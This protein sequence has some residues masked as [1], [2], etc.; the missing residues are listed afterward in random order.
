M[1]NV[2]AYSQLTFFKVGNVYS[3]IMV[4]QKKLVVALIILSAVIAGYF[5]YINSSGDSKICI[6]N[7][8]CFVIEI[9]DSDYER[10]LGLG[11]RDFLDNESGM[12]F[13]FEKETIP[14]LWMKDMKFPIDI[15]WINSDF[16][17]TGIEKDLRPCV[18]G[19]ICPIV[20][21]SAPVKYVFEI[22]AGLSEKYNLSEGN[23]VLF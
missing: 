20:Y 4:N 8:K 21:P 22:N 12:L 13:V 15:I 18:K 10:T 6:E 23:R 2:V 19:E 14:G 7:K 1:V 16:E 5:V 17:I 9:A 3:E 11:N